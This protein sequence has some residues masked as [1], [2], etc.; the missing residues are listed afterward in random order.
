MCVWHLL[1]ITLALHPLHL[2]TAATPLPPE[3]VEALRDI[4]R[5]AQIPWNETRDPCAQCEAHFPHV[6]CTTG[7]VTHLDL[8]SLWL[9]SLPESIG[10]L[11][12]LLYLYV[13]NNQL[14]S[15]P[16]SIG[17]LQE[18]QDLNLTKNQLT[19]LPESIG[20]FQKLLY[21]YVSNNQLAS[22]PESIGQLQGLTYL[23]L[24]NNQLTSFCQS[25]LDSCR[26]WIVCF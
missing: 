6:N 15:L 18:L 16:E 19:S 25:P 21:L 20:Q 11:Q 12:K 10:R 9:T 26:H 2:A 4:F 14:T 22:L 1:R 13:S 7:H 17:Q 24:D 8:A 23:G 3:E 5:V